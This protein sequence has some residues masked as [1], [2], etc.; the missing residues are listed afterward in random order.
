[1]II[2]EGNNYVEME[3]VDRVPPKLPSSGDVE[4]SVEIS[5]SGFTGQGF[6]WIAVSELTVFVT[7]LRQLEERRQGTAT[8]HGMSPETFELC[9]HSIDRKGHMAVTG[10]ITTQVR[11]TQGISYR[12]VVEFGFEFDPTLL[13]NLLSGFQKMMTDG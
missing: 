8:L 5:S 2:R 4:L 3:V 9:L 12:H 11:R 13:L 6:A 10:F 7:Q 1:M